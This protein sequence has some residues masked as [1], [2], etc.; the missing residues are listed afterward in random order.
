MQASREIRQKMAVLIGSLIDRCIQNARMV[1]YI[2]NQEEVI[3]LL[4]E[5]PARFEELVKQE[6]STKTEYSKKDLTYKLDALKELGEFEALDA[7]KNP[8][9]AGSESDLGPILDL[10]NQLARAFAVYIGNA[11]TLFDKS[12]EEFMGKFRQSLRQAGMDLET[13]ELDME[14]ALILEERAQEYL[15]QGKFLQAFTFDRLLASQAMIKQVVN[16]PI[17]GFLLRENLMRRALKDADLSAPLIKFLLRASYISHGAWGDLF[18]IFAALAYKEPDL[19]RP[20]RLIDFIEQDIVFSCN[21][22]RKSYEDLSQLHPAQR[23]S[24]IE[25]SIEGYRN[26]DGPATAVSPNR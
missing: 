3:N 5:D 11:S 17:S 16:I 15:S 12:F 2:L 8:S 23:R 10:I 13:I 25:S 18:S 26:V 24:A 6:H 7:A 20:S 1:P 19:C 22:L 14:D 9:W 4:V 21:L